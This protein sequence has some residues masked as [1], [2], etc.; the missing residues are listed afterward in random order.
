[1]VGEAITQ[2]FLTDPFT[3]WDSLMPLNG[4]ASHSE[5]CHPARNAE[6]LPVEAQW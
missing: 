5:E 6:L 2:I 3:V 1:M 4:G